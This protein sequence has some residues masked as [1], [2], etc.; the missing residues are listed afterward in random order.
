MAAALAIVDASPFTLLQLTPEEPQSITACESFSAWRIVLAPDGASIT[1]DSVFS[2]YG[3]LDR[4]IYMAHEK[5]AGPREAYELIRLGGAANM[6]GMTECSWLEVK[7]SGYELK[8]HKFWQVELAQDVARFANSENG[9]LLIIGISSQRIDG[10]DTLNK[11]TPLVRSETRV[12]SYS[13][14]IDSRVYPP[15]S[16]LEVQAIPM[17]ERELL[18]IVIPKQ[19]EKLKPF[20]VQGAIIYGKYDEGAISISR[21]RGEHSIP[22]TAREIHAMLAAGRSLIYS[23]LSSVED[24]DNDS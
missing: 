5:P 3:Q 22:I 12:E 21:R 7:R 6:I 18:C 14:I 4:A 24:S 13:K 11:L 15:I 23:K 2:L 20:L 17:G 19:S 9:G 8:E 16:N 1:M 10:C